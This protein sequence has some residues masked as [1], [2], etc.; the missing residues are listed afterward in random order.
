MAILEIWYD[1]SAAKPGIALRRSRNRLKATINRPVDTI[2]ALRPGHLAKEDVL[3]LVE[4]VTL[5][6]GLG[7]PPR[8]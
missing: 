7:P 5:K 1:F 6:Q 2:G 3:A 4:A 8:L